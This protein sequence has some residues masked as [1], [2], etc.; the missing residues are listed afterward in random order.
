M[1][2]DD[3]DAIAVTTRPGLTLSLLVGLRYAKHLCR[4]YSK[5][6]IPIHH[7]QAHALT[8]R[9]EH[10]IE[11]PFLCLLASGG[12]CLLTF[13]KSTS[14]FIILGEAIDD[15]PGE[16]FDKVAR[17]MQ[18]KNLPQFAECNGGLAIEV[19]AR[20]ARDPSRYEFPLPLARDRNCQFSFSG[21]KT[22]AQ[23]LIATLR[24]EQNLRPDEVIMHYED[25]CASF[26]QSITKQIVRRTQRAMVFCDR[27]GLWGNTERR[28]PLV[29]S[30][31]VACNDFIFTAL[32]QLCQPMGYEAFRPSK[33]FCMD[34]GIMIAWNGIERWRNGSEEFMHLDL[35]SIRAEPKEPIGESYVKKLASANIKC[36]WVPIP[37]LKRPTLDAQ[38]SN[39]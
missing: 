9:V 31:G 32:H 17:E 19:A 29:F 26:L 39:G 15:A 21:M 12:H 28:R 6:L 24:K 18:L 37:I 4:K 5:P 1:S 36:D 20:S 7:M 11:Y 13:V 38:A 2:I 27:E 10:P 33:Q 23:R 30:G 16:C 22:A 34:N 8:A 14:D 35:D 3:V 25:F